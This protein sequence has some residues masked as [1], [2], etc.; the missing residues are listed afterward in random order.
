ME[1]NNKA[2]IV[3]ALVAL[4]EGSLDKTQPVAL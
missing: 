2:V 1:M 4:T 3:P